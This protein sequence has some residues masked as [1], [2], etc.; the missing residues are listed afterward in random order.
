MIGKQVGAG[1]SPASSDRWTAAE[2][3]AP[4]WR[5]RW[6]RGTSVS[7]PFCCRQACLVRHLPVMSGYRSMGRERGAMALQI[8]AVDRKLLRALQVDSHKSVQV[9]GEAVGLS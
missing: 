4:L 5:L 2:A 3:D 8:D 9:L 7:R 6:G 1:S